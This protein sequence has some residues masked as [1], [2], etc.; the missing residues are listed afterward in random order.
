MDNFEDQLRDNFNE[1]MDSLSDDLL[2]SDGQG[3]V[4]RVSPSFESFYGISRDEAIGKTVYELEEQGYFRPSVIAKVISRRE[5]GT[6]TQKNSKNRDIIVT[7]TPVFDDEGNIKFVVSFSRDITEM[8]ELQKRYSSLRKKMEKYTAEL[9]KLRKETRADTDVIWKSQEMEKVIDTINR[10]AD[11]DVNV[12]LLGPSGVGKTMLARAMHEK[13]N[14][15]EGPFIDINCAAIPENL[16]ES[17]LFGYEKGAFSGAGP[18]GKVGL[19]ELADGGTLLL[20]EISEL[21]LTLQAKLLKAIQEKS[22]N[23]VGGTKPIKVDFRLVAAS[24]RPLDRYAEEGKFRKDLYYRLNVVSIKIPPLSERDG[25]V[26]LL[27]DY[28]TEKF[29]SKYGLSKSFSPKAKERMARYSWPGN[30]RELSNVIER[31]VVTSEGDVIQAEELSDA[32]QEQYA[33]N[34]SDEAALSGGLD[35]ALEAVERNIIIKAYERCHTTVAV[36]EYLKISQPTAYRKIRK[37]VKSDTE[38][39]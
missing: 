4:M 13:S 18:D 27:T 15:A 22:V 26:L 35:K 2:I 21:P 11:I 31:A 34:A 5:K 10:V 30:V 3:R 39:K 17:E 32:L 12:L 16:L 33:S 29:S 28:F 37:Y 36:A 9:H 23:R 20:D 14:R 24:N 25:D 19:M 1:I 38:M 7:A 6:T 8:V